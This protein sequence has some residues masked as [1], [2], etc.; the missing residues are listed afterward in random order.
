M[1]RLYYNPSFGIFVFRKDYNRMKEG[2]IAGCPNPKG[3]LRISIDGKRNYAHRLAFL[4][5]SGEMP[6]DDVDHING[7]VQ[8]NRWGNLRSVN[9]SENM[10]NQKLGVRSKSGIMGV[11]WSRTSNR[12]FSE[13]KIKVDGK[14]KRFEYSR[15]KDFFEAC[16]ARK[17]AENKLGFHSNHGRR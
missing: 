6:P 9:K 3:Y 1:E 14:Y 16:C 5:M 13:T 11:Y 15:H 10:R 4:Y 7:N 2:D 12:W 8:D 17:S